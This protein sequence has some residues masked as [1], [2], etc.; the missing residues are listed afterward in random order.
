MN[1]KSTILVLSA[2]VTLAASPFASAQVTKQG[3]GYLFRLKHT[4]GQTIRYSLVNQMN[5]AGANANQG[6][7]NQ[8]MT[9]PLSTR[10]VS[11]KGG[12]ATIETSFGPM[13]GQGQPQKQTVQMD[14]RGRMQGTAAGGLQNL[15]G[16]SMPERPVAIGGR[17]SDTMKVPSPMGGQIETTTNYR[18]VGIK[19]VG[20]RSVA[21]LAVSM[22]GKGQGL[23]ISGTGTLNVLVSDGTL[24]SMSMNQKAT[25]TPPAN[26]Q[27]QQGGAAAQPMS[28]NTTVRI[29]R[30]P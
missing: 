23:S 28:F 12:I 15:A 17:W 19:S 4:P 27:R 13:G 6:G 10:V 20:G 9:I 14:N 8:S 22:N 18:F 25:I 29:T 21:E 24:W 5:M 16:L 11:V 26:A 1:L 3:N 2:A 7:G 30:R